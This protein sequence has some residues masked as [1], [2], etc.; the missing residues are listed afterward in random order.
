MTNKRKNFSYHLSV[1]TKKRIIALSDKLPS[2]TDEEKA[3]YV[4]RYVKDQKMKDKGSKNV[5]L[6]RDER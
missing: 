2:A 4:S 5:R 3:C 1:A 6:R